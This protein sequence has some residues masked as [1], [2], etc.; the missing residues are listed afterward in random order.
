MDQRAVNYLFKT[1]GGNL[2]HSGDS[3][4][5]NYYAEAWQRASD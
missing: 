1:P 3:H 2:Y 4:Y 5:S